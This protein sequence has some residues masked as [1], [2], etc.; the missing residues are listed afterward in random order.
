M[1]CYIRKHLQKKYL[2][3]IG[4]RLKISTFQTS[5]DVHVLHPAVTLLQLII[6]QL[7]KELSFLKCFFFGFF[8]IEL[9][10]KEERS[11]SINP[12]ESPK[13]SQ[14]KIKTGTY[15]DLKWLKQFKS[16]YQ[17][18]FPDIISLHQSSYKSINIQKKKIIL[19]LFCSTWCSTH[20]LHRNVNIKDVIVWD[21]VNKSTT[22][23]ILKHYKD[24][25][26]LTMRLSILNML[27][28][29]FFNIQ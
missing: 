1:K 4:S 2:S 10:K 7:F 20:Q 25:I 12:K 23:L 15:P 13:T 8:L 6:V 11:S 14:P 21:S 29:V 9:C 19:I 17:L 26:T 22:H 16:D 3:F 27:L 24:T 18:I 5:F 28:R